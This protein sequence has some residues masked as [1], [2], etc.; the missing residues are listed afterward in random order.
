MVP[1]LRELSACMLLSHSVRTNW[2]GFVYKAPQVEDIELGL[3]GTSSKLTAWLFGRKYQFSKELK[4]NEWYTICLTWSDGDQTLRIYI[5]GLVLQETVL[6][7]G[8]GLHHQL[9]RNGTLTLGVS[10]HVQP[11]G[12]LRPESGNKLLGEIGLFRMWGRKWSAE[13]L[14]RL[15]CADGDVVSW[16]LQQWKYDCPPKPDNNLYCGNYSVHYFCCML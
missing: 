12:E 15:G 5:N 2:T 6:P 13:E 1:A 3:G 14:N 10:H 11:N 8:E 4:L 9:A 16:D 7:P